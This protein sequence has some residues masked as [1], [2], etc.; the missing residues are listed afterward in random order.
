M[1]ST[2]GAAHANWWVEAV[3][4]GGC[5]T[6]PYPPCPCLSRPLARLIAPSTDGKRDKLTLMVY[7]QEFQDQPL[8]DVGAVW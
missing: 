1:F 5:S 3:T 6:N 8:F 7:S 2:R 4:M